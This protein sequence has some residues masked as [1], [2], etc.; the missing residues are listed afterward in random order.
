MGKY[1]KQQ[2]VKLIK[3]AIMPGSVPFGQPRWGN[4]FS[5]GTG[6]S[7]PAPESP[8]K[9][10]ARTRRR[11]IQDHLGELDRLVTQMEGDEEVAIFL[12]KVLRS[13]IKNVYS[14]NKK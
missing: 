5:P 14:K 1:T 9:Q 8:E 12:E 7:N 3:E 2:L 11:K 4:D 13:V 10:A 6:L